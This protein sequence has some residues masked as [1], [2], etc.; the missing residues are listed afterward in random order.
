[1]ATGAGPTREAW[2]TGVMFPGAGFIYTR[3]PAHFAVSTAAFALAGVL[4]FG[5]GNHIAPP[6]VWAGAA[7]LAARRAAGKSKHWRGTPYAVA[8]VL[9]VL[10]Y[11]Q[12]RERR[13]RFKSQQKQAESAN[14]LLS[15]AVPPLRGR[16]PSAGARGR[17]DGR[18]GA[19][20]DAALRRHGV[21]ARRRLGRLGR[22]RAVPAGRAA[23]PDRPPD[24]HDGAAEVRA[25][26]G[27]PRLPRRGHAAADRE[28]PAEEGLVL[29]GLR[30]P[31]GQLRV[32][33]GSGPQAEHHADRLLRALARRVPDRHRRLPP[34]GGRLD[35]VQVER[36]APL[37]LLL[38]HALRVAHLGL[39]EVTVGARGVRAELDLLDLQHARRRGSA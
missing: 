31:L 19:R 34:S 18:R 11:E 20:A 37:P 29:L 32:E 12:L 5:T 36:E 22:H 35:R 21:Q 3:D 13:K 14:E 15:K 39:P 28:V 26:A 17:R 38:R 24:L 30:E 23:L 7:A 27:L 2:A 9:G 25:H 33:P 1:M 4:W 8:T 10:A 16:G 6:V